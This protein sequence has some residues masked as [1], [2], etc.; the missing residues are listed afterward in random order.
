MT[1]SIDFND[2]FSSNS[3]PTTAASIANFLAP[4]ANDA[5]YE[6]ANT[7]ADGSAYYDSTL[8]IQKIYA[9]GTWRT[10]ERALDNATA[11]DP[12][13]GDDSDDGY[14]V[15]SLWLN[16]SS[17][18]FFRCTDASVGAAVWQ[19]IAADSVLDSHVAATAVHGVA[20]VVG[21][22]DAQVLTNKT[23]DDEITMKEIASP[24]TPASGDMALYFKTDNKLY[25]KDDAG[26]ET[27]IGIVAAGKADLARFYTQDFVDDDSTIFT[28]SGKD[29]TPD[30]AGTGTSGM[31]LANGTDSVQFL[32]STTAQNSFKMTDEIAVGDRINGRY[33]TIT[34]DY[35]HFNGTDG[36]FKF[37]LHDSTNDAVLATSDDIFYTTSAAVSLYRNFT[38]SVLIPKSCTNI[39]WGIQQAGTTNLKSLEVTNVQMTTKEIDVFQ[40]NILSADV[41]STSDIADFSFTGITIGKYYNIGGFL[42]TSAATAL[43]VLAYSA[44][45]GG[46]TEYGEVLDDSNGSGTTEN[47]ST[48]VNLTFQAASTT[49]FFRLITPFGDSLLGDGTRGESNITLTE[50][51]NIRETDRF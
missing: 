26:T 12:V 40:N 44:A 21:T 20:E 39:R 36:L 11:A 49:L 50:L 16:T 27:E 5:A 51:N 46:G 25:S 3:T 32:S 2:G 10:T 24:S 22:T 23:F 34:M 37:L 14:E 31:S 19:E 33:V 38:A 35:K 13:A 15:L 28:V 17:G 4:Y 18:A 6:A 7:V 42:Y 9:N 8:H 30:N 43:K 45:S 1:R 41:S 48:G 29:A 47:Q